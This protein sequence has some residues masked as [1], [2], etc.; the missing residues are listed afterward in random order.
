MSALPADW[1]AVTAPVQP[2]RTLE[3]SSRALCA[4]EQRGSSFAPQPTPY[5]DLPEST[6]PSR[7]TV[8]P[9]IHISMPATSGSCGCTSG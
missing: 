5:T 8:A 1:H 6:N 3:W 4:S 2:T 9:V 7:L